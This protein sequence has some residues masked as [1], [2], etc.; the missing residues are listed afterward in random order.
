MEPV[1]ALLLSTIT[2]FAG[3]F[4]RRRNNDNAKLHGTN[5]QCFFGDAT[6]TGASWER[7]MFSHTAGT[8]GR[9][10]LQV[11]ILALHASNS[12]M[13][14]YIIQKFLQSHG[15]RRYSQHVRLCCSIIPT[16]L[17]FGMHSLRS[18]LF[19]EEHFISFLFLTAVLL[20]LLGVFFTVSTG[21]DRHFKPTTTAKGLLVC[22]CLLIMVALATG[23]STGGGETSSSS[24]S[25]LILPPPPPSSPFSQESPRQKPTKR[26][27]PFLLPAFDVLYVRMNIIVSDWIWCKELLARI[28]KVL[29]ATLN[30]L[31]AQLFLPVNIDGGYVKL[32]L[33]AIEYV[34]GI[35]SG[36]RGLKIF[37]VSPVLRHI[38]S[39]SAAPV[40]ELSA[41]VVLIIFNTVK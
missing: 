8:A 27:F 38:V 19:N 36:F 5:P 24:S 25:L 39:Y 23:S 13:V 3:I 29:Q 20:F 10:V 35:G 28:L 4:I 41:V 21:A 11:M 14:F 26:Q 1:V 2:P 17:L 31:K 37:A 16:I 12:V 30:V 15:R 40:L 32:Q 7:W 34:L 9:V 22:G 6:L 33:T 18:T